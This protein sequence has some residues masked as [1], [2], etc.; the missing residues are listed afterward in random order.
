MKCSDCIYNGEGYS[1]DVCYECQDASNFKAEEKVMSEWQAEV[2]CSDCIYA[3]KRV[4]GSPC[5]KC[6]RGSW[7][8][9]L[10]SPLEDLTSTTKQM[11][12]MKTKQVFDDEADDPVNHPA[13]YTT[14]KIEVID[15]IED[16]QL[17]FHEANV[18]KYV[19]RAKL[20]GAELQDLKKARVYLD[21]LI[22]LLSSE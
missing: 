7:F 17:G 9:P 4:D 15:F 8:R 6:Q 1:T 13:H 5:S 11:I 18:I 10:S 21:R 19:C 16:K 14:G 20:K 12:E 22:S 2:T 3:V